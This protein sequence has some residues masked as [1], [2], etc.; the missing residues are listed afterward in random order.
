MEKPIEN[1]ILDAADQII[2]PTLVSTLCIAVVWFPLFGL[3]GVA[4]YLFAPM[5]EAVMIAMLASFILSYTR[6]DDGKV[7]DEGSSIWR[8][9][10]HHPAG[11]RA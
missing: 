8:V 2:V 7:Y 11:K 6:A 1:A 9:P 10:A 4:G 3:S 5:A